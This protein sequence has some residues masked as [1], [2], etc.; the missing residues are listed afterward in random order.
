MQ[1][2]GETENV[3]FLL[4]DYRDTTGQFSH[5]VSIEMFEAVGEDYWPAYFDKVKELLA[6]G[7]RAAR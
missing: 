4:Q 7:G 2:L 6:P 3:E 1:K 5:I